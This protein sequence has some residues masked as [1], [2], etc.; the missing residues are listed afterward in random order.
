MFLSLILTCV[1]VSD[2]GT[3]EGKVVRIAVGNASLSCRPSKSEFGLA[4][5]TLRRTGRSTLDE[6]EGHLS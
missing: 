1:L 6:A 2:P 4:P 3:L 5:A